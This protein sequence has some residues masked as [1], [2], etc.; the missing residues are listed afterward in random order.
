VGVVGDYAVFQGATANVLKAKGPPMSRAY[1]SASS[2]CSTNSGTGS[3]N[4]SRRRIDTDVIGGS[5]GGRDD[6]K[7]QCLQPRGARRSTI[8][9]LVAQEAVEIFF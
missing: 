7:M 9:P 2:Q 6:P 4:D 8:H 1:S 5:G 3:D